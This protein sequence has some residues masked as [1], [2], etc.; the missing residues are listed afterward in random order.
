MDKAEAGLL[1][2]C[3]I[4]LQQ[5]F[6]KSAVTHGKGFKFAVRKPVQAVEFIAGQPHKRADGI[7]R[8]SAGTHPV[9]CRQESRY[10]L[11]RRLL[12]FQAVVCV[13]CK[14]VRD[15]LSLCVDAGLPVVFQQ[16]REEKI[17][18]IICIQRFPVGWLLIEHQ[19][20]G[21][22]GPERVVC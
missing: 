22:E 15:K 10:I 11:N 2:D 17:I 6:I 13:L 16:C 8:K 19:A 14:L 20:S 18:L 4:F 21:Q 7:R 1:R 3:D 5:A 9:K 12:P